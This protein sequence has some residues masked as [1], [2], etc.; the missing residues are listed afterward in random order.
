[1]RTCPEPGPV[2][3][4][5]RENWPAPSCGQAREA[6]TARC[7]QALMKPRVKQTAQPL[8]SPGT[9]N[10]A[11]IITGTCSCHLITPGLTTFPKGY[12]DVENR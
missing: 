9:Q 7:E 10:R 6:L 5:Q 1:M 2:L 11:S 8:T 4:D 12:T 3:G